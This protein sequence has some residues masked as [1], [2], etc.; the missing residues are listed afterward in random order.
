MLHCMNVPPTPLVAATPA[1]PT[2]PLTT[3]ATAAHAPVIAP[4][5]W[6]TLAVLALVYLLNFLDRTLIYILFP[7]IKAELSFSDLQLALLGSTSFVLFYTSLGIPFGRLAD[8]VSRRK[9]IA[10]GLATWSIFSGMTGFAHDFWTIFGCRVMVGVGEA[11]LGPAAM[12]WLSDL[13]PRERRGT[14]QSAYSAG[15]PLGAAAAFFL[16][17]H[18]G[19]TW[20][21][22]AAFWALG[23]PGL[24]LAGV[25]LLL[26][27]ARRAA[28]VVAPTSWREDLR[29]LWQ[30]RVLRWHIAGY[31]LL[32]VASNS[33][34]IWIPSF[35]KGARGMALA[36]IGNLTGL[37]MAISGGLATATGGYL[38]DR[39]AA[40]RPAGRLRFGAMLALACTPVWLLLL[41]GT[42]PWMYQAAFFLLAGLGL[43]WLGPAAADVHDLVGPSR[44]GVGVAA[45]ILV[46][47]LVGYGIAPPLVGALSDTLGVA[48]D[49]LVQRIAL[50]SAPV[51]C[52]AAATC[53]WRGVVL[54]RRGVE[55]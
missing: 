27:E 41:W 13:F 25:V 28:A 18:L 38:A 26:P 30:S 43:A 19:A 54:T 53:L 29:A 33:L 49:P 48:T 55:G 5:A 9:L 47:N 51:A 40:G 32:A 6:A 2:G 7:P 39:I 37:S 4:T 8:R 3:A 36:D 23:F 42:Q 50:V 14:V 45:Y 17:G 52:L 20:G 31:A 1:V 46:V 44:R 24:A 34:S 11:T 21:W 35:L 22:R 10:I 12:S 16:G 15:I